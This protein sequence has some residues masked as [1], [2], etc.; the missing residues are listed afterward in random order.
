[1]KQI[2]TFGVK[3]YPK[4]KLVEI[5]GN[6]AIFE[7]TESKENVSYDFDYIVLAIGI[8]PNKEL[9]DEIEEN[10]SNVHVIGDAKQVGR[11][12]NAMETG[13]ELAY[14]L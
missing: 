14:K 2:E 5:R 13:F 11:I 9:I 3:L 8:K 4:H 12:R 6:R 1:L 7:N 10:F